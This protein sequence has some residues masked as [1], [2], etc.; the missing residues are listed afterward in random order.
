MLANKHSL[1]TCYYYY[2]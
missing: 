2:Y 1:G